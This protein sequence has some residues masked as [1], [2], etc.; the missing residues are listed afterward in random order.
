MRCRPSLRFHPPARFICSTQ[1]RLTIATGS[2]GFPS[3]AVDRQIVH[4][5]LAPAF[6]RGSIVAHDQRRSLLYVTASYSIDRLPS[7]RQ[8]KHAIRGALLLQRAAHQF[9]PTTST[10]VAPLRFDFKKKNSNLNFLK[11]RNTACRRH[12]P[13]R[14]SEYRYSRDSTPAYRNSRVYGSLPSPATD[15]L[16]EH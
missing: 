5:C 2:R 16:K 15:F 4:P 12:S 13:L 8:F 6:H 14:H 3:T 11:E 9:S 1:L 7:S 10:F